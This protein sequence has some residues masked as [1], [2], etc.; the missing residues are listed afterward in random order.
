MSSDFKF[1]KPATPPVLLT[2]HAYPDLPTDL[3]TVVRNRIDIIRSYHK[4]AEVMAWL[5]GIVKHPYTRIDYVWCQCEM[6]EIVRT[7]IREAVGQ[8]AERAANATADAPSEPAKSDVVALAQKY[9]K[10]YK[11]VPPGVDPNAVDTYAIAQ[12]FP[13]DDP[14]GAI[15]HARKK[16]LIP[17]VRSGG[18]SMRKDIIE[19]RDTLSRWL[20]LNPEA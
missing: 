16:L 18:K 4:A 1:V 10:Y 2:P 5:N 13:V 6:G 17:G 8:I 12:M 19:A 20:D 15:L 3:H 7:V 9:P 11:A 14:S